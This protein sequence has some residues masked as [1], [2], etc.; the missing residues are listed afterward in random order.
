MRTIQV[1]IYLYMKVHLIRKATIE[2]FARSNARSRASFE[3]WLEKIKHAD[4]EKPFDMNR[5]FG[6]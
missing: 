3:D 1:F 2:V 6:T 4:W 5:T